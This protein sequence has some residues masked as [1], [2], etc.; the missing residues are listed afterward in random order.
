M[1]VSS[2]PRGLQTATISPQTL[3][4]NGQTL[5]HP[6]THT[7]TGGAVFINTGYAGGA[8]FIFVGNPSIVKIWI[9]GHSVVLGNRPGRGINLTYHGALAL[10]KKVGTQLLS[11]LS[12]NRL[13]PSSF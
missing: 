4:P 3:N 10:R 9:A 12:P 7:L 8:Y 2:H 11:A 13:N 6:Q 1:P 5:L